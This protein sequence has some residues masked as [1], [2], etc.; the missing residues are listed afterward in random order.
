MTP[1][2]RTGVA[3]SAIVVAACK[4]LPPTKG[5]PAILT[6]GSDDVRAELTEIVSE[7]LNGATITIAPDA[8]T[9]SPS[10]IIE[11]AARNSLGGMPM[12]GRRID[13]PDHFTLSLSNGKCVLTH[14]ETDT[15]YALK[16]A[17]CEV[18]S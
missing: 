6:N 15:H 13:R 3:A 11:R 1:L 4:T 7:A 2:L 10:L 5:A 8:L 9:K 12:D 17:K 14:E 16:I 18:T